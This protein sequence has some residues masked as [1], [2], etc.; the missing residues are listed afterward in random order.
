VERIPPLVHV[1]RIEIGQ[2]RYWSER[3]LD[4]A[5][6]ASAGVKRAWPGESVTVGAGRNALAPDEGALHG[7]NRT[8]TWILNVYGRARLGV[9]SPI[10]EDRRCP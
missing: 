7:S 6:V 1:A 3:T 10:R 2:R 8:R 4:L 5:L 9:T